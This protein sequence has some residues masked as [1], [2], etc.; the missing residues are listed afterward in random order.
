MSE[1]KENGLSVN[2]ARKTDGSVL[3]QQEASSEIDL[4]ELFFR[5]LNS[6]KLIVCLALV[7]AIGMGVYSFYFVTPMYQATSVIYVL[8]RS[9]SVINMSDLQIG[10][11]LTNDYIKVFSMWEVH[12]RVIS[13]LNLPYTYTQMQKM[14]SVANAANTRMLDI[15]VKSASPTEAAAIANAYADVVCD[16]ISENMATDKPSIMSIAL[17]PAN[18]VSPNKTRN[19]MLGFILGGLLGCGIVTV[20]MLLDDKYKTADDIRKYTGLATLATIPVDETMG[21]SHSKHKNVHSAHRNAGRR[22][23]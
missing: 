21:A 22:K 17:V 12:E 20:I 18:P 13:K 1:V 2:D 7:F 6:W 16:Y 5:L 3:A 10:S 8:N 15:T 9:D 4:M 14:V 19:V 23:N 11:A